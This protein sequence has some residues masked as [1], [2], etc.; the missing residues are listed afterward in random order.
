MSKVKIAVDFALAIAKDD[1]HGYDQANRS[2][3]K[4]YDCSSLVITSF[5]KAGIKV[6]EAGATY[7]GNMKKA[8]LSCGFTEVVDK[9][10]LTSCR[11]MVPGDVLLHEGRHTAIYIGNGQLVHASINEKGTIV[12]GIPGDQTGKEICI[13]SY[14]NHPWNSVL[15]YLEM[16]Y[17]QAIDF[18][19]RNSGIDKAYWLKRR[20]IDP[21]FAELM[22]KT[23]HN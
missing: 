13:R 17:E 20:N 7:T 2:N 6:K 11:G 8:F 14:Y 19:A 16:T 12:G 5:E 3:G 15:R 9:V 4:D 18:H 21:S 10:G 23:A 1:S 22:I